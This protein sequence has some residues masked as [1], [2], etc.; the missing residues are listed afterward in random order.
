MPGDLAEY[1]EFANHLADESGAF[2]RPLFRKKIDVI[3]KADESPVTEADRGAERVMRAIISERHPEHGIVGEEYGAE[4]ADAEWVWHLDPIDGT[5]SFI[6]GSAQ[7]ASLIALCQNGKPVVGI[8]NQPVNNERW[9]GVDGK[10]T[11]F[12]GNPISTRQCE[13]LGDATLYTW[14]A[15]CLLGPNAGVMQELVRTVQ[16]TRF[17]ADGYAYGLLSLGFVDIV[18]DEGMSPH[19]YL[20]LAPV[21]KGAGGLITDWDGREIEYGVGEKT[22]AVGDARLQRAALNILQG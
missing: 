5:K 6:T 3:S 22:L 17:S 4:N 7:F 14:G 10:Q 12:N 1:A 9:V 13:G 20:A 2:I 15:E 18:A 21:V 11:T 16:L 19:D 8:I